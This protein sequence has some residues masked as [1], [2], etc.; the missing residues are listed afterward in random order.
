MVGIRSTGNADT[1]IEQA[2]RKDFNASEAFEKG[3]PEVGEKLYNYILEVAEGKDTKTEINKQKVLHLS[4]Y[5]PIAFYEGSDRSRTP[6]MYS[7]IEA[8]AGKFGE[9]FAGTGNNVLSQD[10]NEAVRMYTDRVR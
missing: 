10:Y 5:V 4:Y 8:A 9:G 1:F 7:G 6:P 3:I 2:Y